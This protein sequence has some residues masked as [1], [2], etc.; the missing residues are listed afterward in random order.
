MKSLFLLVIIINLFYS[1]FANSNEIYVISKVNNQIIT[2]ADVN[3]EYKYLI[4]LNPNLQRV[5]KKKLWNFYSQYSKEFFF[6]KLFF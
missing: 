5:E 3:K 1:S 4:A 6:E 2:N